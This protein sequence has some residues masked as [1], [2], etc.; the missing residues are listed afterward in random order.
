LDQT[1]FNA[2]RKLFHFLCDPPITFNFSSRGMS[3]LETSRQPRQIS[4]SIRSLGNIVCNPE[5]PWAGLPVCNVGTMPLRRLE[6]ASISM[7]SG[8]APL[9]E[10]WSCRVFD[11]IFVPKSTNWAAAAATPR[12][13]TASIISTDRRLQMRAF[14]MEF[15]SD[16]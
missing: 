4:S 3:S 12:A 1:L 15:S 7:F 10:S 11:T 9:I 14:R 5:Y 16:T 13:V 2:W 6:A 8:S